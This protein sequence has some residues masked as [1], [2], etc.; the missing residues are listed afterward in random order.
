MNICTHGNVDIPICKVPPSLLLRAWRN[1]PAFTALDNLGHSRFQIL[2][3]EH[4]PFI[5]SKT[6]AALV[7]TTKLSTLPCRRPQRIRAPSSRWHDCRPNTLFPPQERQESAKKPRNLAVRG[8]CV[9]CPALRGRYLSRPDPSFDYRCDDNPNPSVI[10]GAGSSAPFAPFAA[11]GRTDCTCHDG[12]C[13]R[14]RPL[15]CALLIPIQI[16]I[17]QVKRRWGLTSTPRPLSTFAAGYF[18]PHI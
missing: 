15:M 6:Y 11:D 16:Y 7:P 13:E 17:P 10:P 4:I 1:S 2:I 8:G 9:A 12:D 3:A 18:L 5:S 14:P